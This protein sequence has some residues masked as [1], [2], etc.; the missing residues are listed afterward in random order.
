MDKSQLRKNIIQ[1]FTRSGSSFQ[2]NELLLSALLTDAEIDDIGLR[3]EILRRLHHGDTQRRIA[4]DLGVG[5]ATV[6]R[7]SRQMQQL[8]GDFDLFLDKTH[9]KKR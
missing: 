8:E 7:G 2:N 4:V 1:V 3:L 6:T 9:N 5:V